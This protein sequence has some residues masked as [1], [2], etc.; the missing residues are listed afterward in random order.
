MPSPSSL[1]RTLC[2]IAL[3]GLTAA[4]PSVQTTLTNGPRPIYAIAH[5]VLRT[6]AVTAA[7]SHGANALEVDLHGTDEW[8]ADH[9]CKKNSAGDTARELFQF[10]AEER[11]NGAN[12]TFIW[13]DIKNPDECPQHEPC[14]I[15]AL[16]DLVR[17]TLEPVGIRAL[18]GFYQTEESQ[19]YKEI[20]H[21]LNE[22]EAISLSGSARDVFEMYFT[23]S[24]SL[25][26][27]Q[28]IMDH[29]D[30]NIQKNF[31]D[32]HER[33]GTTCSELRNG[34]SA[35]SRGQLG[36][37]FAWTSTEGDT[38]YV[39]DLLSVAQVDGIIYG[40]QKH[41]YKDE[42]RT[43]NAFWDILDFVKANPD[44]VRMATADDAPW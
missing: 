1:L 38:R 41:D 3:L 29:G 31:G 36:K 5:R 18:Y 33:G 11:R 9:D 37:I 15:Q 43:R 28:R 20:L 34:R 14:S 16:R 4:A 39:S 10:I 22:N 27:K 24:R 26:V 19:G 32:C 6:E 23:T 17:E 8:W 35:Q 2:A 13:L 21:S 42:A 44:A 30:V 25:P 40:S 7:I 12:I